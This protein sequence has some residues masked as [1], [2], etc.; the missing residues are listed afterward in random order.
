MDPKNCSTRTDPN[1]RTGISIT[2]NRILRILV[3]TYIYVVIKM[4]KFP[5]PVMD[6]PVRV[7]GS[8][9]VLAFV[10]DPL[11]ELYKTVGI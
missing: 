3:P 4:R 11:P 7:L 10:S 8:V 1:T 9:C 2:S 5:L 6:M